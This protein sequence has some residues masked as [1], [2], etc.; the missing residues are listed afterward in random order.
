MHR[1]PC[2]STRAAREG[3]WSPGTRAN[4][5]ELWRV[6]AGSVESSPL[7]SARILYFGSWDRHLYAYRLRGKRPL[8]LWTF[9]AD[10]QIVA[11][12]AYAGRTLYVATSSGS[13]YGVDAKTGRQRWRAT[14]FSRFGRREY[15]YATPTVAYG[16]VFIGNADG[17]VYAFG[18]STG[19][20][21]GRARSGRTSTRRPRSGGRWSSSAP[22]T[23]R[24]SRSTR[25]PASRAGGSALRRGSR[26]RRRSSP[27]SSTSRRAG[28]AEP[29]GLRRVKIGPRRNLRAERAQRRSDLA[30]PRR[31]VLAA[32]RRR[33]GSTS[34]AEQGVR[35]H[36]GAALAEAPEGEGGSRSALG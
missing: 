21:S 20:C 22:G 34:R 24:S 26:A 33:P 31:Q 36:S 3:S 17:T 5:N 11:A 8:L 13:V 4:G 23:G 9:T 7:S 32:R 15:F 27:A 10:D 6:K 18:A 28:G 35:A 1:L 2:R 19:T 16:R 14:S 30:V 12:P 29:A 25:A